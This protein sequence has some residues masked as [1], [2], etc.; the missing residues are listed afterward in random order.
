MSPLPAKAILE[1]TDH[2]PWVM[3]QSWQK[4]LF[5]HWAID[6]NTIRPLIPKQLELDTFDGKA[7]IGVVPF[8]MNHVH[9]RGMPEVPMTNRFPELNVRT[10]VCQGDKAGVWFFSLDAKSRLAVRVARMLFRLPYH[11]A[12]M[13]LEVENHVVRYESNRVHRQTGD[14]DFQATYQATSEPYYAEVDSLEHW[15]TERYCLYAQDKRGQLYRGE[16]HHHPWAL[17]N[18]IANIDLNTMAHASG[19]PLPNDEP[20]LHYVENIDVLTWY[21]EK[22]S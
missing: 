13:T 10:Y 21:L 22:I 20:L 9:L 19:I 6:P 11:D 3:A 1:Q 8:L 5:A 18:A 17:Q 12:R 2:R 16:I 4:L 7:W 15:L 14:A